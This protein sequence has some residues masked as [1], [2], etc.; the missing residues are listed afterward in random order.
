[1]NL[2]D[3]MRKVWEGVSAVKSGV[4]AANVTRPAVSEPAGELKAS[5]EP[6]EDLCSAE[7]DAL[8]NQLAREGT[9]NVR[10]VSDQIESLRIDGPCPRCLHPF[11]QTRALTIPASS[12]RKY[13]VE[14][15]RV[16]WGDF[17]CECRVVH[18][19]TPAGEQG[20]GASYAISRPKA[21]S[22]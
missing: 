1:M 18:P 21:Q 9:I 20:C 4:G 2:T 8:A 7:L 3:R 12:I 14:S 17:A 11:S 13:N 19:G 22:V 5:E 10:L 15:V 16:G 6:F